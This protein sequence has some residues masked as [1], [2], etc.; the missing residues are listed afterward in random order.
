[1]YAPDPPEKNKPVKTKT[2]QKKN[3]EPIAMMKY[4]SSAAAARLRDD[5]DRRRGILGGCGKDVLFAPVS[6][7]AGPGG[8][9]RYVWHS[10]YRW[11]EE[12]GR[13]KGPA[14]P[15][16]SQPCSQCTYDGR[17]ERRCRYFPN[18]F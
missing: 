8:G 18:R 10:R 9:L 17:I 5:D 7:A 3:S 16:S 1:L 4:K 11:V 15:S 2:K 13:R 14:A 12:Q 6:M